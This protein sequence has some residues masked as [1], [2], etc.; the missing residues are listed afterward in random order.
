MKKC[1]YFDPFA[2]HSGRFLVQNETCIGASIWQAQ[3]AVMRNRRI[4]LA[5]V[6][7]SSSTKISFLL[8][9]LRANYSIKF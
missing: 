4:C 9:I 8:K 2:R 7:G 3:S 6:I 5:G 1:Q